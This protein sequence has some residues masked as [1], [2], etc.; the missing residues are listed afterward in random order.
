MKDLF[1]PARPPSAVPPL[2]RLCLGCGLSGWFSEIRRLETCKRHH[3]RYPL[4]RDPDYALEI[5]VWTIEAEKRASS[6][7]SR[8]RGSRRTQDFQR[9]IKHGPFRCCEAGAGSYGPARRSASGAVDCRANNNNRL[10]R[11]AR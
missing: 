9:R 11:G 2:P 3:Y 4:C 8:P 1:T 7:R 10:G 5:A 6:D